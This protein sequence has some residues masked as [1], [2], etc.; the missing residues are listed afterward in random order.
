MHRTSTTTDAPAL[1]VHGLTKRFGDVTA[2]D[3]LSFEVP[4]GTVTGFVGP[5]GSGK[6]T[7]LRVLLGLTRPTAG[8]A[9]V[10]GRPYAELPNPI[11]HLGAVLEP[12][13]HPARRGRDHLRV[14]ATAADLPTARVE[15]VLEAT[16]LQ[17]A[18]HRRLKGWSLGMRQRLALATALLGE[19]ATLV[20]DEPTNGLDPEGVHWLRGFLRDHADRGGTVLVSSHLLAELALTADHVVIV[21]D[22]RLVTAGPLD[23]LTRSMAAGVHVRTPDVDR[24]LTVLAE[25]GIAARRA[26][27]DELVAEGATTA[28][29]GAA[30][31]AAG[32]VV[33]ELRRARADLE[34]T[35]LDLTATPATTT[36]T[37]P[38][39]TSTGTGTG[40]RGTR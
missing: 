29:V 24:L 27:G 15:A 17:R 6:T 10:D 36:A 35:F 14:V 37:P 5:N 40:T 7:T 20:L 9:L 32:V 22:G 21:K 30:I 31:A 13:F 18:A 12:A 33:Y 19:P 26:G 16:D 38:D 25:H 34:A 4:R 28:E 3:D 23:A 11:R 1:A 39:R 8:E 2:V